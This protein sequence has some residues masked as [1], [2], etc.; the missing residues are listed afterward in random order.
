MSELH[1]GAA[2]ILMHGREL[3][4][5]A[6][7]CEGDQPRV[8]ATNCRTRGVNDLAAFAE[9]IRSQPME[10]HKSALVG[11]AAESIFDLI[12]AAEHYPAFLP[13]CADAKILTRDESVVVANITVNY[14]GVRFNFTTRNPKRRPEWMAVTLERGPFRRF[15]GEWRLTPLAPS[16]CK[17]EFTFRYDFDAAMVRTLAGP[18]FD[19]IANTFVDAF[20]KRAEDVF[21]TSQERSDGAA[22][23]SAIGATSDDRRD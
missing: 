12:E 11:Y 16:A 22:A 18:V 1:G 13:W 7:Y 15:E 17:I 23:Q 10:I 4:P 19:R 21:G 9:G 2:F 3:Y 14:H 6:Q 5:A 20:V 8:G